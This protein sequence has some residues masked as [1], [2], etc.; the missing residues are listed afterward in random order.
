MSTIQ[1]RPWWRSKN[2]REQLLSTKNATCM[3]RAKEQK[4]AKE[5]KS[6]RANTVHIQLYILHT[7]LFI[8][9]GTTRM[10]QPDIN[11]NICL[12]MFIIGGR[13]VLSVLSH[14]WHTKN[15]GPQWMNK[16]SPYFQAIFYLHVHVFIYL[17]T[18]SLFS[19]LYRLQHYYEWMKINLLHVC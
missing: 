3:K 12:S 10:L 9:Y 13:R 1:K 7:Y 2:A 6:K 4:W 11:N 18:Y 15:Q 8:P 17:Y 19:P 5:Q 16:Y 14:Y